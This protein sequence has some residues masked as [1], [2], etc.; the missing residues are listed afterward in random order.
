MKLLCVVFCIAIYLSI[1]SSLLSQGILTQITTDTLYQGFPEIYGDRI[2]WM[3]N[4]GGG[5][6]YDI[7]M[8]DITTG[9]ETQITSDPNEQDGPVIWED[10]IV[11]TDDRNG[12]KDIYMYDI[13]TGIETQITSDI[14]DQTSPAVWGDKIVWNDYRNNDIDIYMYDI[15]TGTERSICTANGDQLSPKIW[16]HL[17]VWQDERNSSPDIYMYD[18]NEEEQVPICTDPNNQITP[19]ICNWRIVWRDNRLGNDDIYLYYLYYYLPYNPNS[20]ELPLTYLEIDQF[21]P[22]PEAQ[23]SPSLSEDHLVF[24]QGP[25]GSEDVYMFEFDWKTSGNVIP[26]STLPNERELWPDVSMGKVVWE[27]A[28][29][30]NLDI[31]MWERAPGADLSIS[32]RAEPEPVQTGEYL[33]YT[34]KIKN[35]GPLDASGVVVLDTLPVN[36][37]FFSATSTQGSCTTI[38]NIVTGNIGIILYGDVVTM[39]I[40]VKAIN[41]GILV[42]YASV[43]GNEPDDYLTNNSNIRGTAVIDLHREALEDGWSPQIELDASD[44][45][46]LTYVRDGIPWIIHSG[47]YTYVY[48]EDDIMYA[49]NESGF[50]EVEKI[51]DGYNYADPPTPPHNLYAYKGNVSDISIDSLGNIHL[52]YIVEHVEENISGIP[53]EDKFSIYYIKRENGIWGEEEL[54]KEV[55]YLSG[56][57]TLFNSVGSPIG[58]SSLSMDTDSQGHVYFL[59]KN[60]FPGPYPGELILMNNSTGIWALD[61]IHP[62][63]YTEAELAID[64]NDHHH[65]SFYSWNI[66]PGGPFAQGIGYMTN[67][68]SGIWQAPEPIETNWTGSQMEPLMTDIA[69]DQSNRPHVVYFSGA[70][71]FQEDTRYALKDNNV[72]NSTLIDPGTW[73]S[74]YNAICVDPAT[75][76]HLCYFHYQSEEL[77]Y[78]TNASGSWVINML[79]DGPWGWTSPWATEGNPDMISNKTNDVHIVYDQGGKIRYVYLSEDSDQDSDGIPDEEEQGP[80][81]NDPN[82]DGNGDGTPDSQQGNVASFPSNDGTQYVTLENPDTTTTLTNVQAV[83]KPAA[84]DSTAPA[85]EDAPYGFFKFTILGLDAGDTTYVNFILHGGPS[86]STYYKYS[87]TPDST[88]N[89]WYQFMFDGATGAV[90]HG[91]TITLHFIDGQRGDRDITANG[92]V[93]EPGAPGIPPTG[94]NP[95]SDILP[96]QFQLFQNYPNPFNPSTTIRYSIPRLSDVEITIFNILGQKVRSYRIAQ[97]PAGTYNLSWD[98]RNETNHSVATGM[99]IY[100]MK[101]TEFTSVKKMLLIR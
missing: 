7:Y 58:C 32:V 70:G 87:P 96:D 100:R 53:V 65:I 61:T 91:D 60:S 33:T 83:S 93:T 2:V 9:I 27:D 31:W 45:L 76:V 98:G 95:N 13:S 41:T 62:V 37:E 26:I 10:I 97:Q 38:G 82:Y 75:N 43:T 81:G 48:S 14:D 35:S 54:V 30:G 21:L 44:H 1:H 52:V 36:V 72:W 69:L 66:N 99:Y 25:S 40:V 57:V 46:H 42:N 5:P 11:W 78:A 17:I 50:W 63:I 56:G 34:V 85:D 55:V 28:R 92:I 51:F 80:L 15:S 101:A 74:S 39:T 22:S 8:Y 71:Q 23:W 64:S 16:Q 77:R 29:S 4:R 6:N 89:H 90:I 68:P 86:V 49:T 73:T 88:I 3:D 94:I 79:D 18:L 47:S 19:D 20:L 67:S 12:N 84:G 24:L 59:Y